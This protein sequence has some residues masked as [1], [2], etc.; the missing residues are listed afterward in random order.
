MKQ[1]M[2]QG[3]GGK[4]ISNKVSDNDDEKK[5]RKWGEREEN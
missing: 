3:E 4:G 5:W 2:V 1:L